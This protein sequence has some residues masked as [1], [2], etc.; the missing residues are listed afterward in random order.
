MNIAT[1]EVSGVYA[2]A[3]AYTHIPAGLVGATVTF[4]FSDPKW[5][6]L[7]KTAVFRGNVTRDVIMSDNVVKV[8]PE[9]VET[10]GGRLLIGVYGV[11]GD[12]NIVIPTLWTDI[13]PIRPAADPS[14]DPS[15][16]PSLP[17]WAQLA[18]E[19]EKLKSEV[20]DAPGTPG[21]DG[22]DGGYYTPSLTQPDD[23]T[24]EFHF[25]PSKPDMPTVDPVQVELPESGEGVFIAEYGVTSNAE[26]FE[27]NE[28]GKVC[29]AKYNDML[30]PIASCGDM[31]TTFSGTNGFQF[32]NVRCNGEK[33]DVLKMP[34]TSTLSESSTNVEF[35]TAKA[36]VEYVKQNSGGNVDEEQIAAAVNKWLD[37]HPEAT[38]TVKWGNVSAGEIFELSTE[39]EPVKPVPC[40]GISLDKTE[41]AFSDTETT[42]TLVATVTPSDTTDQIVWSVDNGNVATVE[43]G[44][45]KAIAN[46]SCVVTAT[47]GAYSATCAVTVEID[48]SYVA[49]TKENLDGYFDFIGVENNYFGTLTNKAESGTLT[50]EVYM[51]PN[52]GAAPDSISVEDGVLVFGSTD[53]MGALGKQTQMLIYTD[54]TTYFYNAYPYSVEFYGKMGSPTYGYGKFFTTMLC[55]TRGPKIAELHGT[56][57]GTGVYFFD[58]STIK[59]NGT[60]GQGSNT[61]ALDSAVDVTAYH[62]YVVIV[63]SAL[64]RVYIDGVMVGEGKA[65]NNGIAS[66]TNVLKIMS[67]GYLKMCRVYNTILNDEQVAQNYANTIATYGG[68]A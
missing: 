39:E 68:D 12:N 64:V 16:D 10:P 7:S 33:W 63:D 20:P 50:G 11:D 36:V 53:H 48:T 52:N 32:F 43:N 15:V 30:L 24:L 37:E 58:D 57:T 5:D 41:L 66:T 67:S 45:V 62:H 22:E 21:Q 60:V 18:Q 31:M 9:T 28:S 23:N 14:G 4:D 6:N 38:T 27:A 34:F 26:I 35:P 19:I 42:V 47:C 54:E 3:K 1:I 25:T 29:F 17:V 61:I 8:P 65:G 46:G 13:G 49:Y 44:A 59:S 40:T 55:S 51:F 56:G 2:S